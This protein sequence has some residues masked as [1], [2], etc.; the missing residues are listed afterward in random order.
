MKPIGWFNFFLGVW[1]VASPFVLGF[2]EVPS[3]LYTHVI[4]GVLIAAFA[5]YSATSALPKSRL[6]G[7]NWVMTIFGI[8]TVL[9][10]FATR[11]AVPVKATWNDVIVGIVVCF[12]AA[13]NALGESYVFPIHRE[14]H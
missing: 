9:A 8:L 10:P 6:A 7:A 1:L 12:F 13:Y 11:Y 2:S 3:I 14:Q 4:L 5:L